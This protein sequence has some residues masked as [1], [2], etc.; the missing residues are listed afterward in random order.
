M[1]LVDGLGRTLAVIDPNPQGS[2][3][4]L[5]PGHLVTWYG[6]NHRGQVTSI[7]QGDG[8]QLRLFR[9]DLLG[10]LT[11]QRLP[12]KNRTLNGN[13][14]YVGTDPG[15][16]GEWTDVFFYDLASNLSEH[17]D[18]RGVKTIYDY[19]GDPLHRL[20]TVTYDVSGVGDTSS[21]VVPA[22]A[23]RYQYTGLGADPGCETVNVRRVRKITTVGVGTEE[24]CYDTLG[25]LSST[26]T[27]LDSR[28]DYSMPVTYH[29]ADLLD[30]VEVIEHPPQWGLG[31]A[32]VIHIRFE[33][34]LGHRS[35][36]ITAGSENPLSAWDFDYDA[37]G[38]LTTI[39]GGPVG[40]T[41]ALETL[42][43]DPQTG[44]PLSRSVVLE[45]RVLLDLCYLYRRG[46]GSAGKLHG[47]VDKTSLLPR[48]AKVYGYDGLGRLDKWGSIDLGD[49][50]STEPCLGH[51]SVPGPFVQP[52]IQQY[53]YDSYGNRTDVK[54]LR[55]TP[56]TSGQRLDPLDGLAS[57]A[58]D[59]RTNRITNPGFAYDAAGNLTRAQR[60]DGTWR[61]YEYDAAGRLA[62]V[63]D[64]S[65]VP[66]ETYTYGADRRRL[67]TQAGDPSNDRTYYAWDGTTVIAEYRETDEFPTNP[68]WSKSYVHLGG[69]LLATSEPTG[70]GV[71]AEMTAGDGLFYATDHR[72]RLWVRAAGPVSSPWKSIGEAKGV[73]SLAY[74]QGSLY[75]I[76]AA[77]ELVVRAADQEGA[78]WQTVVGAH[79]I[80]ALS[81]DDGHLFALGDDGRLRARPAIPNPT[82]DWMLVGGQAQNLV[83]MGAADGTLWALGNDNSLWV[84]KATLDAADWEVVMDQGNP[85]G[86]TGEVSGFA[87]IN[88][89]LYAA[90][91]G[92]GR[93]KNRRADRAPDSTWQDAGP[94]AGQVVR[95][96]YPDRLGTRLVITPTDGAVTKQ[97]TMPFGNLSPEGSTGATN[98]LFTS[99]DRGGRTGLDYAINRFYDPELG[100]FLQV[101]PVERSGSD[102]S[103]LNLYSY[104]GN[105]PL[106]ATDPLG[107]MDCSIEAD[108]CWEND[109]TAGVSSPADSEGW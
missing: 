71:M 98:R 26:K 33:Y 90:L 2:G 104:V 73:T 37:N 3:S 93:M 59:P 13:G 48:F 92:N 4:V 77:G 15:T 101:D 89:T 70:F 64:D 86:L 17:R 24:A 108:I 65:G 87:A 20:R 46:G 31:N 91:A 44:L 88:G 63:L 18:A 61:R 14:A 75:A 107:L 35:K 6:I 96:H 21:L 103:R 85:A 40:F 60:A 11:H 45:G 95:Y 54:R 22:A 50:A 74:S 97:A 68:N 9:Y 102:P 79:S 41:P 49:G 39:L 42:A 1:T 52:W 30:R 47:I 29:Y 55:G 72:V 16:G 105:D 38:Q 94:T 57:L 62:R 78:N 8:D 67:V 58:Y 80:V 32:P 43:N 36:R 106:N 27:T 7:E 82:V 34:S 100:R 109:S 23:V 10:R 19:G 66:L 28:P 84:R 76:T 25:R 51:A 81:A 5:E 83:A 99:F 69:R 53:S 12:E 56:T